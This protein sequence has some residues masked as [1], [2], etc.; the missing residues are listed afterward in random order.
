MSAGRK[1]GLVNKHF[2]VSPYTLY[3]SLTRSVRPVLID[4]RIAEDVMAD[5]TIVPGAILCSHGTAPEY[6]KEHLKNLSQP[7]VVYCHKGRK[8]S[9]GVA[10][11]LRADGYNALVLEGGHLNWQAQGYPLIRHQNGTDEQRMCW[12][13]SQTPSVSVWM[14]V[15]V[16][17]RFINPLAKIL[18]VPSSDVML[19][20]EK[21]SARP[22]SMTEKPD[23]F[24]LL[25]EFMVTSQDMKQLIHTIQG[26]QGKVING[27][28]A[29]LPLYA[30]DQRLQMDMMLAVFDTLYQ[31]IINQSCADEGGQ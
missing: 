24:E 12:V 18:F 26:D 4:V 14:S 25:S 27:I 29:G 22:F 19:V 16:I 8:L 3:Q 17:K 5:P 7:C 11:H 15:W 2:E 23:P 28:V 1:W 6:V 31:S 9:Q 13:T 30:K 10:A 20:A 21:F